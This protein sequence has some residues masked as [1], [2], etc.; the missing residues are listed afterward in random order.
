MRFDMGDLVRLAVEPCPCG[1]HE[2]LTLDAVEGRVANATL[3]IA[4]RLVTQ[5]EA[6]AAIAQIDGVD[7]YELVQT[8]AATVSLRYASDTRD[9]AAIEPE[10][11]ASLQRCYGC[12]VKIIPGHVQALSPVLGVKYRLTRA[13]FEIDIHDFLT[14]S[15]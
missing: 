10:L 4:G 15:Q 8:D 14:R 7:Q 6:D 13:D 12:S 2:G 3:S 11:C 5:R 1:R 9:P